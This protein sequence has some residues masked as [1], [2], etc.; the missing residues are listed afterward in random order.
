MEER[1]GNVVRGASQNTI[2]RNTYPHK[3][4]KVS[5]V[6]IVAADSTLTRRCLKPLRT[7]LAYRID[8]LGVCR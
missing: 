4:K 1:L 2:E 5:Q 3:Y 6:S 8:A 7:L